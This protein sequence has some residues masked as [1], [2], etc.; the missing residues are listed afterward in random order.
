V[1]QIPL[2]EGYGIASDYIYGVGQT[3]VG[4]H[5]PDELTGSNCQSSLT[6]LNGLDVAGYKDNGVDDLLTFFKNDLSGRA[7][8][9]P[10]KTGQP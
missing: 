4:A 7:V 9:P 1:P 3:A 6:A 10:D 2:R 8:D 5:I